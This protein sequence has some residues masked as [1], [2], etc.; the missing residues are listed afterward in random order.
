MAREQDVSRIQCETL[1]IPPGATATVA[2]RASAGFY[3]LA[4]KYMS[5]GSLSISG[6]TMTTD[7]I[8]GAS[9]IGSSAATAQ[10]YLLGTS[11]VLNINHFVGDFY[12]T[13]TGSTAVCGLIR[14]FTIGN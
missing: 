8:N 14:Q 6:A 5:G 13:A 12:L 7:A 9:V 2:F 10:S 3:G 1:A 4:L 11:E